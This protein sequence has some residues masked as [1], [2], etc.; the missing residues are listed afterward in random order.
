MFW[1]VGRLQAV[2]M[3][4][5]PRR[6]ILGS[7]EETRLIYGVESVSATTKCLLGESTFIARLMPNNRKLALVYQAV[8]RGL[9]GRIEIYCLMKAAA[10]LGSARPTPAAGIASALQSQLA[11]PPFAK[12]AFGLKS[13]RF[14]QDLDAGGQCR[15]ADRQAKL[16]ATSRCHT[17]HEG[18]LPPLPSH[19]G[20]KNG[21]DIGLGY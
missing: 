17:N 16:L 4:A 21:V 11:V 5:G 7:R 3:C 12:V 6:R 13:T 8:G 19:D 15:V 9:K 1:R 10:P 20:E 2:S 14:D 18:H